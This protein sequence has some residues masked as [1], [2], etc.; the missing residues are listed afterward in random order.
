MEGTYPL[1]EAQLDRFFFKLLVKYPSAD[2]MEAIL[3]RTT[4]EEEPRA[5]AIF[6]GKRIGELS[7]LARQIPIADDL[8]RYGI[9]L[10]L[11][12][13]PDNGQATETT[14]RYV[15]YGSSPRGA[16]AMILA[17]KIKAILDHRY[18]VAREDLRE[19]ARP[20]LRHRLI[21][22]FEGQAE[23]VQ[24]DDIIDDILERVEMPALVA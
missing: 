21:L 19:V 13:H 6:D 15:R 16:Q 1:P 12:T 17:A 23:N 20:A 18:H 3:D 14:R 7:Q 5:S 2:E 9:A 4:E 10:V 24:A 11:A 22:N 8:R